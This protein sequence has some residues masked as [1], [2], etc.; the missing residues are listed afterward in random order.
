VFLLIARSGQSASLFTTLFQLLFME[1][2][3]LKVAADVAAPV[4]TYIY[5]ALKK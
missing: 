4:G 2:I 5:E 3:T 1:A